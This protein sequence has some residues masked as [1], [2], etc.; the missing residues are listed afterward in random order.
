MKNH[1]F[2]LLLSTLFFSCDQKEKADFLVL[3]GKVYTV[4][5][6]FSTAEAFAV[7]DGKFLAVGSN[8]EIKKQFDAENTIDAEGK[9]IVP[10]LIDAHAH[11]YSFGL[12]LQMVDLRDTKSYD[13]VIEKL[14]A[15]QKGKDRDFITGGGWD[16]NDWEDKNFPTKDTLDKLFPDTP[17][18]IS[19]ID[20]HALLEVGS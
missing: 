7:K 2:I 17:V 14:I 16:Q 13:E 8:T 20:G 3:N 6:T 10:G 12:Q 4:D 19:R 1:L 15:F 9:T 18:A 5:D 11:F